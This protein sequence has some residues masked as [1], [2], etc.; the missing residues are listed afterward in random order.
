MSTLK[1]LKSNN[2]R[3]DH[4]NGRQNTSLCWIWPVAAG[5][6]LHLSLSFFF[7]FAA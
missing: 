4:S 3:V 2:E 6:S 1:I 7:F 5:C